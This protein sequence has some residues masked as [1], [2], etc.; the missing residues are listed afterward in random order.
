M[1]YIK[2]EGASPLEGLELGKQDLVCN[3]EH[4]SI[5]VKKDGEHA[6]LQNHALCFYPFPSWGAQ[7]PN[8]SS[9]DATGMRGEKPEDT[10]LTMHPEAY[11][12]MVEKE[13]I[14]SEGVLTSKYFEKQ[15]EQSEQ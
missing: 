7:V 1:K 12:F 4:E 5:W 3:G 6:Y 9:F 8:K 10:V 14:D 11:D 15:R 2:A 13:W